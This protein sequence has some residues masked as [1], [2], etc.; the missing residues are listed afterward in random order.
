MYVDLLTIQRHSVLYRTITCLSEPCEDKRVKVDYSYFETQTV[1]PL[2]ALLLRLTD[3]HFLVHLTQH[4]SNYVTY[5]LILSEQSYL[6]VN[7]E[8]GPF[9]ERQLHH[10][11]SLSSSSVCGAHRVFPLGRELCIS[12]AKRCCGFVL[13]LLLL[14]TSRGDGEEEETEEEEEEWKERRRRRWVDSRSVNA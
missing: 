2:A 7:C 3:K 5:K 12:A 10:F 1:A 14:L 4:L 13:L 11:S 8:R 9:A 6:R